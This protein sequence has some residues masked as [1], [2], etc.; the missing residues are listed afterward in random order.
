MHVKLC[1]LQDKITKK[2]LFLI[3]Q[4]IKRINSVKGNLPLERTN[5]F[6]LGVQDVENSKPVFDPDFHTELII[7]D[8]YED[9]FS[10]N[11]ETYILF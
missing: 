8:K 1:K 11:M 7:K 2:V 10:G 5:V 9:C 3:S 4:S 6:F